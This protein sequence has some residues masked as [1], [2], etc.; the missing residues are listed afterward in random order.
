METTVLNNLINAADSNLARRVAAG[1]WRLA[2]AAPGPGGGRCP[3]FLFLRYRF[4]FLSLYLVEIWLS[5]GKVRKVGG[6]G[7]EKKKKEPRQLRCNWIENQ[8]T[9]LRHLPNLGA[10]EFRL[11]LHWICLEF[12]SWIQSIQLHYSSSPE[13]YGLMK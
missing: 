1:W 8:P 5:L 11:D 9:T 7:I 4:H 10:I 3:H 13:S 6:G 2:T 12:S